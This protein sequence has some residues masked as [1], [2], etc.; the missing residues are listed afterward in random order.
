MEIFGVAHAF[1]DHCPAQAVVVQDPLKG[2]GKFRRVP[3]RGVKGR[4]AAGF[5]KAGA[6]GGDD[7]DPAVQSLQDGDAETFAHGRVGKDAGQPVQTGQV[8]VRDLAQEV[9]P[10]F[11]ARR[12]TVVWRDGRFEW[13]DPS[14]PGIDAE[15]DPALE[16]YVTTVKNGRY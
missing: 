10:A 15:N 9:D 11:K 1:L 16:T 4:V 13:A 5:G 12:T 3:R 8:L 7:R 2:V 6:R 14:T